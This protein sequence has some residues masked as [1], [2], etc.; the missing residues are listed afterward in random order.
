MEA[1]TR[2]G[3]ISEKWEVCGGKRVLIGCIEDELCGFI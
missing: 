1:R 3:N 2:N